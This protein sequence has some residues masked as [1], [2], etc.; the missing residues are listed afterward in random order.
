V[1]RRRSCGSGGGIALNDA[2]KRLEDKQCADF[3]LGPCILILSVFSHV[4]TS[5]K[6]VNIFGIVG[7]TI[8]ERPDVIDMVFMLTYCG[9]RIRASRDIAFV[10]LLVPSAF[11]VSSGV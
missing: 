10:A 2:N 6:A 3:T 4:A 5:A 8:R 7:A 9:Y 11:D 1:H